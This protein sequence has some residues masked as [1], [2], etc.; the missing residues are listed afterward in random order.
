MNSTALFDPTPDQLKK[1]RAWRLS[2]FWVMLIGYI[3]YY[4][5][6]GNL[7]IAIPLIAQTFQYTNTQLGIVLTFSE[8]AYAIGKLTTG[9][10]ADRVGGKTVFILGLA[11][12]VLF[13]VL[14]P[15]NHTLFYFTVIWCLCRYFLSMGWGGLT[16]VI[17]EW[18][19]PERNGTVMGFISINFQFGN[20]VVALFCGW[21]IAMGV[22]WQGLFFIP[23]GVA[24]IICIWS[25][26]A[27]RERPHNVFPG[28]RFG[29]TAGKKPTLAKY[30]DSEGHP[31]FWSVARTLLK[32]PLF[33]QILVFS[34]FSHLLRSIF[35]FW[36][37]KFLV[38]IGMGNVAAA[39]SSAAFPL[40]GCLGTIFLGW[41]TDHHSKGGDRARMMSIMLV[42][43]VVSLLLTSYLIPFREQYHWAIV[44]LLGASGFFLYGPYSMSAGCLTLDIAGPKGAGTCS[45]MIDGLGYIGGAMAAWSAG[46]LSDKLGWQQVFLF[47]AFTSVFAVA[48]TFYM[49]VSYRKRMA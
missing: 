48:W 29:Q 2:T 13:N 25:V 8:L 41:Y 46:V 21:L 12:A 47:L 26:L 20:A 16:K 6:R 39:F 4:L 45:G 27:S 43:L 22:G 34:V 23:A 1:L 49:S 15:L 9:P 19:E 18:Y 44:I 11:G 33:R 30:E 37:P 35:L 38:D 31:G 24:T 42:G 36:I 32:V 17:G 14:F 10:L 40:L 5:V 7:P 28:V 3:G